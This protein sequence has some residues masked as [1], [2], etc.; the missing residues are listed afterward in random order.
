MLRRLEGIY[1]KYKVPREVHIR[2]V[3]ISSGS[4]YS[5][6]DDDPLYKEL[7]DVV[8]FGTGK[9]HVHISVD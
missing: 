1:K 7:I 8:K 5:V 4:A 6:G 9:K 2:D 3:W